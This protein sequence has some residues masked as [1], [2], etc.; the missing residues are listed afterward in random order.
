N[1]PL[2]LWRCEIRFQH[3]WAPVVTGYAKCLIYRS[4][5][6]AL[7][8]R[9]RHPL[10]ELPELLTSVIDHIEKLH[11]K[12]GRSPSTSRLH[13]LLAD[14]LYPRDSWLNW[15]LGRSY[16]PLFEDQKKILFE[17]YIVDALAYNFMG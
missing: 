16:T 6:S 5:M 4:I 13:F 15:L 10:F 7:A 2:L 17:L 3:Q 12:I 11:K 1:F 14:M 8:G 9:D